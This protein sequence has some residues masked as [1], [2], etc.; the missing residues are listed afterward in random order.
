VNKLA[1]VYRGGPDHELARHSTFSA[2]GSVLLAIIAN[3][4]TD[5]YKS[6]QATRSL[7]SKR[8]RLKDVVKTLSVTT[9]LHNDSSQLLIQLAYNATI[10]AL[11]FFLGIGAGVAGAAYMV[12]EGFYLA[13]VDILLNPS[14]PILILY[15]YVPIAFCVV[16]FIFFFMAFLLSI[17]QIKLLRRLAEFDRYRQEAQDEIARLQEGA[18]PTN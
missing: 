4:L 15:E 3:L 16:G 2:I 12:F 17:D 8:Q 9:A 11:F 5:R 18:S 13:G 7:L 1:A 14:F 6:W 10:I